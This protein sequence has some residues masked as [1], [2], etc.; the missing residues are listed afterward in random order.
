MIVILKLQLWLNKAPVAKPLLRHILKISNSAYDVFFLLISKPTHSTF[1]TVLL[2]ALLHT[3][4]FSLL[5]SIAYYRYV[6][7]LMLL[8][9]LLLLCGCPTSNII[10]MVYCCYCNLSVWK[11]YSSN[12]LIVHYGLK[13][14][15]IFFITWRNENS[16]R[17]SIST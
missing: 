15:C 1:A 5:H 2:N 14:T 10:R 9:L 3:F 6:F 12:N 16:G 4:F 11:S 8:L 7:L 13:I 17:S